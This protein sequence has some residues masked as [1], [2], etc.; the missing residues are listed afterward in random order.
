L[1][2][3]IKCGGGQLTGA[4]TTYKVKPNK[5]YLLRIINAVMNN[6]CFFRIGGY[7]VTVVGADGNYLSP[8]RTNLVEIS[9]G[10]TTGHVLLITS[11][12]PGEN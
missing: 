6:D 3:L 10:Q 1:N 8:F 11:K 2:F 7:K 9:P 5:V 4:I 12:T